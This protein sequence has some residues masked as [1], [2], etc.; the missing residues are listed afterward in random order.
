MTKNRIAV[1]PNDGPVDSDKLLLNEAR[2]L[3]LVK[4]NELLRF[5]AE[6]ELVTSLTDTRPS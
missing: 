2:E 5:L 4:N 3:S 1:I 6:K